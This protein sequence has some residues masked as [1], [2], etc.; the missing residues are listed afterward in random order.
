VVPLVVG[1]GLILVALYGV[2]LGILVP[3]IIGAIGIV[4]IVATF[5]HWVGKDDR[6]TW[7]QAV[8][9]SLIMLGGIVGLI[10]MHVYEPELKGAFKA[11]LDSVF[12][13]AVNEPVGY[14]WNMIVGLFAGFCGV[15]FV[16]AGIIFLAFREHRANKR[17][18]G[19][20]AMRAKAMADYQATAA[21]DLL[22][23]SK[24]AALPP[25]Q[26]PAVDNLV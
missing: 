13:P 19:E 18:R 9:V 5:F 14:P 20:E 11:A 24:P 7:P 22:P 8:L 1:V 23:M 25:R 3:F 17:R 6:M 15:A 26:S 16:P 12:G 21:L 2:G 10:F 4:V